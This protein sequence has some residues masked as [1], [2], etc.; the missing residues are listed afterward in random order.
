VNATERQIVAGLD[1][2][3]RQAAGYTPCRWAYDGIK[4]LYSCSH[5]EVTG[6]CV[7]N[8]VEGMNHF[9]NQGSMRDEQDEDQDENDT[10]P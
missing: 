5:I 6:R 2:L 3:H 1:Q 10:L 7:I 4:D 8:H 9:P